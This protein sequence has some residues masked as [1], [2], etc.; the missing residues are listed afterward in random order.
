[1]ESA[2]SPRPASTLSPT[3]KTPDPHYDLLG[4]S[5]KSTTSE[6]NGKTSRFSITTTK[7]PPQYKKPSSGN[8]FQEASNPFM[9]TAPHSL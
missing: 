9:E 6:K 7:G 4:E 1:M 8:P 5:T 3:R 2:F